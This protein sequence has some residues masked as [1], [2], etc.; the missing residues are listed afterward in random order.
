MQGN[1]TL[2]YQ[3][4]KNA[5]LNKQLEDIGWGLILIVIGGL[6]LVPGEQLP[7]G[8]WLI[9]AGVIMLVLNGVRYLNGIKA[10]VLTTALGAL[11]LIGGL[12]SLLGVELPLF[13]IFLLLV[14]VGLVFRP[15][16]GRRA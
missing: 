1:Q 9:L 12:G 5:N 7:Q 2:P 16:F 6:L 10:N 3:E 15:L 8:F 4:A 14:G 13:A 11:A